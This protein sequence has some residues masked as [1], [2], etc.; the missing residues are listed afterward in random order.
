MTTHEEIFTPGPVMMTAANPDVDSVIAAHVGTGSRQPRQ[1]QK[2]DAATGMAASVSW[3]G[4][5]EPSREYN[6]KTEPEG[7]SAQHRIPMGSQ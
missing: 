7:C 4:A 1:G 6:T 5:S 3:A 2:T